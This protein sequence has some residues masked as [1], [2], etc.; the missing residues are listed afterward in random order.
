MTT[1]VIRP[2][3]EHGQTI[4]QLLAELRDVADGQPVRTGMGGAVVTWEVAH[5]YLDRVMGNAAAAQPR[6]ELGAGTEGGAAEDPAPTPARPAMATRTTTT[7]A[8]GP[9]P[10]ADEGTAAPAPTGGGRA[11]AA[12]ASTAKTTARKRTAGPRKE[13]R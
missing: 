12:P 5:A 13:S 8:A 2:R 11:A 1:I 4:A 3:R 6:A 10:A 7:T 9:P